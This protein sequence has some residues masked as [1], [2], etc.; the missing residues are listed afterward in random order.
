MDF[1]NLVKIRKYW[2]RSN[3]VVSNLGLSICVSGYDTENI[4]QALSRTENGK[5]LS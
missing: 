4:K 3:R 1:Y 5:L 2:E